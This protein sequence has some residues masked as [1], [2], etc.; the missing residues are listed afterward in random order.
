MVEDVG[1]KICFNEAFL[2]IWTSDG[3]MERKEEEKRHPFVL[4]ILHTLANSTQ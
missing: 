2:F 3:S 4:I 1:Q